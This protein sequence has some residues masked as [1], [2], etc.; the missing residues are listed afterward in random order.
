MT[1]IRSVGRVS[2][3]DPLCAWTHLP[4]TFVFGAMLL[5]AG[6]TKAAP[7]F[8]IDVAAVS[9]DAGVN[10]HIVGSQ[11]VPIVDSHSFNGGSGG[12]AVSLTYSV[13]A[14]PGVLGGFSSVDAIS[15][16]GQNISGDARTFAKFALDNLLI[17]GPAPTGAHVGYSINFG[18]SGG[19]RLFV[20][21]NS[22]ATGSVEMDYLPSPDGSVTLGVLDGTSVPGGSTGTG[23]FNS[24][25]DDSSVAVIAT[26]PEE[27]GVVGA[28]AFVG[29]TLATDAAVE[30]APSATE[31]G[32]GE[33]I[34]DFLDPFSFPASGPVFNFF[35][36]ITGAPVAG[37]SVNSGDGCIVDNRFLCGAT[38]GPSGGPTGV[39]EPGALSVFGLALLGC[40]FGYP[41]LGRRR[42]PPPP[43]RRASLSRVS[44]PHREV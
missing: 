24:Q 1:M 32:Q 41:Q 3:F 25:T 16:T 37:Y 29:F 10:T 19:I 9:L 39:D 15:A 14:K 4:A 13:V 7:V 23:I 34:T 28:D 33:A 12:S 8:S 42:G 27:M 30:T 17:S 44:W 40:A 22:G 5:A 31:L 11:A 36:L 26:T 2:R 35:D 43:R 38:G 20:S 21:G 18:I 6:A